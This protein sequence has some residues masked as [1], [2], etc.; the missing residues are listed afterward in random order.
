MSE[1]HIPARTATV[2]KYLPQLHIVD[3]GETS[4]TEISFY[5]LTPSNLLYLRQL[6]GLEPNIGILQQL[7]Q[8]LIQFS[9]HRLGWLKAVSLPW[10]PGAADLPLSV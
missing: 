10:F 5:T 1:S 6:H 9:C 2:C 8:L 7:V 3:V 4:F